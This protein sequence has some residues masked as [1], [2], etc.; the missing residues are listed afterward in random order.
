MKPA[1][2]LVVDDHL[3]NLKLAADVLEWAGHTVLRAND[4][5]EAL[6]VLQHARPELILMDLQMPGMDGLTLTRRLKADPA[7]QRIPI[8][9]L[10]AF[11]MKGDEQKARE[12]GCDGYIT[13]PI[14]TRA[15]AGQVIE[16]MARHSAPEPKEP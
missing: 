1:C 12:A 11:A 3:T 6:A 9:A 7:Y 14:D 10:T 5:Q 13:K 16:I 15:L 4:A 8:V 2:I